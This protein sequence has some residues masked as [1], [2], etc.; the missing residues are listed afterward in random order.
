MAIPVY[1]FRSVAAVWMLRPLALVSAS[2]LLAACGGGG[3]TNASSGVASGTTTVD[4]SAPVLASAVAAQVLQPAFYLA[5]VVPQPPGIVDP[6]GTGSPVTSVVT[7][8][9]DGVQTRGL[10]PAALQA[11]LSGSAAPSAAVP[12][13]GNAAKPFASGSVVATYTPAQIRAAYGLPVLPAS[14]SGLTSTQAAQLGAGQTIYLVDAQNDPNAGAELNA[15]SSRFALPSCAITPIASNVSLPLAAASTSACTFSVVYASASGTI[16][17]SAPAYDSGWATEIALDVQWAHATA[18]L[19]RI[20]LVEAADASLNSLLG[21]VQVANNLCK[22]VVSMSFGGGEG[23]WTSSVDSYF[24]ASGM[25]YLAATGDNGAGVAWPSVSSHVVAVGGT[26]LTY[27]GSGPRSEVAW[28][29][30]G[31][32]TSAYT[33]TPSYQSSAVPGMGSVAHRTVADV[34]FN[35]DPATGQYVV[36]MAPGSSA[37]NWFSVGGTSLA[38]PQWAGLIAIANAMRGVT[39]QAALGAPHSIL[40]QQIA[41]SANNYASAFADITKGSD[42]SCANCVAHLGYNPLAGLGTPNANSLLGMLTGAAVAT[43][44]P[45]VSSASIS[46]QVGTALSFTVTATDANPLTYALSGAP[47]GMAISTAGVVTWPTPVAGTYTVT[48]SA[49]DAKTSLS[50]QGVYT[51]TITAPQA[52][53]IAAATING[54]PGTALSYVVVA[55]AADP[56]SYSITGAP[57]GMVINASGTLSWP[58]PV[59]GTYTVTASAKDTKTGLTGS[60]VLTV[61]ITAATATGPSI[62]AAPINGIAGKPLSANIVISDPGVAAWSVSISGIPLGMTFSPNGATLTANWS[63]PVHGSYSLLLHLSDSAGH[64]VQTSVSITIQ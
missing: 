40:Y 27:T 54:Q 26:T 18:P 35:A 10:T 9:L 6:T 51:V 21:A 48:V 13:S 33:A 32:G 61:K 24:S 47:S 52:P 5:P 60:N 20:I 45:V 29:G 58:S 11:A 15:F 1:S 50:G 63:S 38:T 14:F 7:D 8:A 16:T 56:V 44:A 53:V 59:L 41:T 28:T 62:T 4:M 64:S 2:A 43:P 42:G 37:Q 23:S 17:A 22:G 19:A 57:V 3:D 25:T 55:T 31:G 36:T 34:S 30:T 12:A 39:S 46:G 49:K